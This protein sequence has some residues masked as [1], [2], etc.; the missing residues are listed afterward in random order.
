MQVACMRTHT[1]LSVA[2]AAW[3]SALIASSAH[4]LDDPFVARSTAYLQ[5]KEGSA[6]FLSQCIT[7]KGFASLVI[8]LDAS[9]GILMEVESGVVVNAA[10]IHFPAGIMNVDTAESQGGVYTLTVL[11]GRAKD[12]AARPFVL[13]AAHNHGLILPPEIKHRC[14]DRPPRY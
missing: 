7:Q 3:G 9:P 1:V 10:E 13:L 14:E 4:A 11:T 8:P 2:V 12:L 5:R 6:V